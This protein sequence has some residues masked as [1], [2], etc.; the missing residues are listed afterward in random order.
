[1]TLEI[2]SGAI[3]DPNPTDAM[4]HPLAV[5]RDG[6]GTHRDTACEQAG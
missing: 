6:S 1:M 5:A 3:A 2:S 4:T